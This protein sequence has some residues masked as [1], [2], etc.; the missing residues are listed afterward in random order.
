[1]VVAEIV[2]IVKVVEQ[3]ELGSMIAGSAGAGA[4]SEELPNGAAAPGDKRS[5]EAAAATPG[6]KR[7]QEAAAATPGK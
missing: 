4:G 6:S 5:P 2:E 1:M 7:N 3:T